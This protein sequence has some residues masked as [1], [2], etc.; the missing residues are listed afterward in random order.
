ME[1]DQN[2]IANQ[3]KRSRELAIWL[4][5]QVA[6]LEIQKLT[7]RRRCA[8]VCFGVVQDH[9]TSFTLLLLQTPPLQSTAFA[10]VRLLY[11]AY[12]RGTWLLAAATDQEVEAYGKG[13]QPLIKTMIGA[14]ETIGAQPNRVLSNIHSHSWDAMCG[15]AHTGVEH[16][17]RWGNGNVLEPAYPPVEVLRLL[18]L[19]SVYATLATASIAHIAGKHD[20]QAKIMAEGKLLSPKAPPPAHPANG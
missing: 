5:R 16:T 2:E 19:T 1:L 17:F 6:G 10:I 12:I 4:A 11:E 13:K 9:H 3:L 18:A 7:F 14:I 15:L 8:A 20:L